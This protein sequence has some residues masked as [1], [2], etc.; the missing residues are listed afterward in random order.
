MEE[1]EARITF[2]NIVESEED[3]DIT[4]YEV[5]FRWFLRVMSALNEDKKEL[6]VGGE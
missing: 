4:D 2:D 6:P 5:H 3:Y 1:E